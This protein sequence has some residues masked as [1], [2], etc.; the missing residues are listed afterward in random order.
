M[1]LHISPLA[2]PSRC[3]AT[4]S[5]ALLAA[6]LA[7][8]AG[9]A[10]ADRPDGVKDMRLSATAGSWSLVFDEE[11]N[12]PIAWG[13]R[14]IGDTTSAYRYGDHNPDNDKLDWLSRSAVSVAGGVATFTASPGART[15]ENGRRSWT[16][17]L[18]TTE[19]SAEGFKV[20]V[21]DFVETRVKLP[22]APGAWPALWT[23][24]DG[25]NEIDSFEYHPDNPDLLEL[26]NGLR[27]AGFLYRNPAVVGPGSWVTVGVHYGA[28]GNDWYVNGS[29]VFSDGTGTGRGWTAHLILNLSVDAGQ[30]H[31]PP[32]DLEPFTFL[33]DYIRVWR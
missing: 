23:W 14:W 31:Q 6:T 19:G 33:A 27:H 9:A 2:K 22:T 18:L 4:V 11:F 32:A 13:T 25:T 5:A 15:L 21:G 1:T 16:T 24:Q 10:Q 28:A 3:L 29:K 8:S 7:G 17:G 30:Y 12:G 20:R 26:T